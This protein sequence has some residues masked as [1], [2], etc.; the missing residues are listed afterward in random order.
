MKKNLKK[1]TDATKRYGP[2]IAATVAVT[3]V[4][5]KIYTQHCVKVPLF[6]LTDSI[7]SKVTDAPS[8][9]V[10]CVFNKELLLGTPVPEK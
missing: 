7:R 1:L 10:L 5:R 8:G 3:L 4:G 2:V 6:E 9:S